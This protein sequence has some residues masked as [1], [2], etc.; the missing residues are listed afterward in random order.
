MMPV[1]VRIRNRRNVIPPMHH[2]NRSRSAC[3]RILVGCRWRK[4]FELTWRTR[5]RYVSWYS[6]RN[7]DFQTYELRT[8]SNQ[9]FFASA[10]S[11]SLR[12]KSLR[13]GQERP[14]VSRLVLLDPERDALVD[15]DLA[16]LRHRDL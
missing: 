15:L 10:T 8:L 14:R 16:V 1:T 13:I 3:R 11:Q 9:L 5:F 6:C 4:T 7:I 2:V 12:R